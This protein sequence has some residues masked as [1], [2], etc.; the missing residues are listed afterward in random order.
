M[1]IPRISLPTEASFAQNHPHSLSSSLTTA[2]LFTSYCAKDVV[3]LP[4]LTVCTRFTFFCELAIWT[5]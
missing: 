1:R 3:S 2:S 4:L 5:D